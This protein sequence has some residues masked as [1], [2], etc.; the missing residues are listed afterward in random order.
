MPD[1]VM[2]RDSW[3]SECRASSLDMAEVFRP[4]RHLRVEAFTKPALIAFPKTLEP[5]VEKLDAWEF[6]TNAL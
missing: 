4:R 2:Y 5:Q 1:A 3:F 6:V